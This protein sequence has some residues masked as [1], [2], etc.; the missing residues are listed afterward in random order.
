MSRDNFDKKIELLL[1]QQ[2]EEATH[3]KK[4]TWNKISDELFQNSSPSGRTARSKP[5]KKRKGLVVVGLS[6]A[7][8]ITLLLFGTLTDQGQ[9]MFQN[10]KEMFVDEKQ[11]EIELEGQKEETN[12]QLETNEELRYI[13]YVDEERYKMVEGEESD[14]IELIEPLE[15][16]YP[17]VYME[18]TRIEDTTTEEVVAAIKAEI[19][20]D[21]KM[22]LRRE[23]RVT[24]PIEA[25]MV[26]GMGLE[27]TNDAGKTGHQW[28]TP[29][30]RYYVTDEDEGQVFVIKQVYFLEA[31]EGHGARFHYM[32]ESFK[33]VK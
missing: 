14:R 31:A 13:I 18:I 23:E 16:R 7:A 12:V 15:D 25:E 8:V 11:E 27:Y 6:T 21:E 19:E 10:L 20:R 29:I 2:T 30:H 24:E 28:D 5:K 1:Q 26:Q 4:E 9:A 33:V 32:L 3:L 17:D 22:E